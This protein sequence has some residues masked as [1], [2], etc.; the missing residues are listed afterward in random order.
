MV[1]SFSLVLGGLVVLL[2]ATP[3]QADAPL[4]S[5]LR[6]GRLM[7]P[8]V[9]DA[10]TLRLAG[11]GGLGRVAGRAA[12][13]GRFGLGLA[14]PLSTGLSLE[15]M[16]TVLEGSRA[17]ST[18]GAGGD[19]RLS[20][21]GSLGPVTAAVGVDLLL[22]DGVD[23]LAATSP[24]TGALWQA[25]AWRVAGSVRLDRSDELS[26]LTAVARWAEVL[27]PGWV[28]QLAGGRRIGPI[29]AGAAWRFIVPADWDDRRDVVAVDAAWAKALPV[30]RLLV[31]AWFETPGKEAPDGRTWTLGA[32]IGLDLALRPL[33]RELFPPATAAEPAFSPFGAE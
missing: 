27:R 18:F 17:S 6:F 5:G 21:A 20:L 16:V 22:A 4:W 10:A 14:V 29:E 30:G 31:G 25:G 2:A 8:A 13:A 7:A 9:T 19:S 32:R 28:L 23:G 12:F 24:W 11:D 1:R 15:A 33:G 26:P 3:S